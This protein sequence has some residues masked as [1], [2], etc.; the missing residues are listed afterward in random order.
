MG[1]RTTPNH[2]GITKRELSLP[3][4]KLEKWPKCKKQLFSDIGQW[5]EQ[6]CVPQENRNQVSF[7]I[8]LA[9][10]LEAVSGPRLRNVEGKQRM[11]GLLI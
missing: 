10:C 1:C 2:E 9:F 7:T 5:A 3:L 6:D 4:R 11:M 8:A